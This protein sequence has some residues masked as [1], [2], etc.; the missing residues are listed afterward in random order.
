MY[1]HMDIC[2]CV[3]VCIYICCC[4]LCILPVNISATNI[5]D[6]TYS[7][8][9][10]FIL[11][12][13]PSLFLLLYIGGRNGYGAKLTNIFSSEFIVETADSSRKLKYKQIYQNNMRVKLE[14]EISKYE[15]GSDYTCVT[16]SPDLKLFKMTVG[17]FFFF[18]VFIVF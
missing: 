13:F 18:F 10:Y 5:C 1:V 4:N 14:P 11:L 7:F 16:F 6:K 17:I 3:I 9:I 15:K 8:I 12:F 2:V